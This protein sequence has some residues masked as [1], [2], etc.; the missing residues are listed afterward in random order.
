M[1]SGINHI[2]LAV[3]NLNVSLQFYSEIP[4]CKIVH[5]WPKGAY[6]EAGSLWLCLSVCEVVE[7]RTDYTHIAFSTTSHMFPDL[8]QNVVSKKIRFWKE[9]SSEG[10]SLYILD[11]DG[12]QLEI[13]VGSLESR[14]E[15]LKKSAG[16]DIGC[17]AGDQGSQRCN[18]RN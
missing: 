7:S 11:P 17:S 15:C 18:S 16:I 9:N 5:E 14:M 4:G 2:T 1:I 6:L 3:S 10:D 12:H 8:R 13:H